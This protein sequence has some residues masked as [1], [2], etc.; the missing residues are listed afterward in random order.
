M[1]DV[2]EEA[3]DQVT[4]TVDA[5]NGLSTDYMENNKDRDPPDVDRIEKLCQRVFG[6]GKPEKLKDN[7]KTDIVWFLTSV[8]S[9]VSHQTDGGKRTKLR[10]R[11][12]VTPTDEAFAMMALKHHK[13]KWEK[14]PEASRAQEHETGSGEGGGKEKKKRVTGRATSESP[15]HCTEMTKKMDKFHKENEDKCRTGEEWLEKMKCEKGGKDEEKVARPKE[16]VDLSALDSGFSLE[17]EMNPSFMDVES[18]P[19]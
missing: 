17:M 11:E 2:F 14:K 1:C 16:V 13:S 4:H 3:M 15:Q 12:A 6:G 8:V 5:H 7:E 19:V 10:C 18:E 9:A